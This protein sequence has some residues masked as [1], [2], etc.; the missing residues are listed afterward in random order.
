MRIIAQ[1][2]LAEQIRE[3]I[4]D[5]GNTRRYTP[6]KITRSINNALLE[7]SKIKAGVWH[8]FSVENQREYEAPGWVNQVSDLQVK[9]PVS[10]YPFVAGETQEGRW[11]R[12]QNWTVDDGLDGQLVIRLPRRLTGAMRFLWY[13]PIPILPVSAPTTSTLEAG[14]DTLGCTRPAS[15]WPVETGWVRAGAEWVFYKGIQ[16][17]EGALLLQNLERGLF[18]TSPA[19]SYAGPLQWG[20][21]IGKPEH[22]ML[23]K[24]IAMKHLHLQFMTDGS[25]N[26]RDNHG[27]MVQYWGQEQ[28]R[29]ARQVGGRR[30][31]IRLGPQ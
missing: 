20:V 11:E 14:S 26:E 1:D 7:F 23:L 10:P 8:E 12:L 28:Q 17:S 27:Q 31:Q 3:D 29:L 5:L 15:F 25:N 2:D 30:T 24:A 16:V 18:N 22:L 21:A 13:P 6:A 19:P 9:S 4:N